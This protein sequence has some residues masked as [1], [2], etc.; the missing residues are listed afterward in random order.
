VNGLFYALLAIIVGVAT[1]AFGGGGIQTARGYWE[2]VS[3]RAEMKASETRRQADPEAARQ[4][5]ERLVGIPEL[6]EEEW[7]KPTS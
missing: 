1:V 4:Q 2:R 3:S 6:E 5:G 7:R